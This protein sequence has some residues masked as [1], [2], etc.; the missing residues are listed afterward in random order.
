MPRL[1]QDGAEARRGRRV[2]IIQPADTADDVAVE[3]IDT[4]H[5]PYDDIEYW[6]QN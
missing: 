5:D 3:D 1:R 2:S 6:V 4:E